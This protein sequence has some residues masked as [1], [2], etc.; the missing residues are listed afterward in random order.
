MILR[1]VPPFR[2]DLTVWALRRRARNVIDRWDG[3]TYRRVVILGGR[4]TELAV[5]QERLSTTPRLIVTVTP[6]FETEFDAKRL[7]STI[8]RLLGLRIDLTGW[9]RTAERDPHLRTSKDSS[10]SSCSSPP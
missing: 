7:R 3:S 10:S 4:P 6:S 1:P 5:R 8:E 2:L 9:Y